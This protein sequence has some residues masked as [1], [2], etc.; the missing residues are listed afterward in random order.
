MLYFI[1]K[2]ALSRIIIADMPVQQPT[3]YKLAINLKTAKAI[4]IEPPATLV[5]L[6]DAVLE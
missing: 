4:G 5:A 1:T 6:A 3:T 2:C